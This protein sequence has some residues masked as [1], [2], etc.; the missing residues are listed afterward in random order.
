MP[1]I[2]INL[3]AVVLAAVANMV[4]GML[5]YGPLFG[6]KWQALMGFTPESMKSMKMTAAQAIAG[7]CVTAF[8]MAYV[9]AHDAFVWG[10]FFGTS[11]APSVFA[12]QLAFWIWLGYVATTQ[13]GAV[14]WEGRP[15]KLFVLNAG[16]SLVSLI[17]MSLILTYIR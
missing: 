13:I 4:V 5:W 11:V 2:E 3:I 16:N 6:K 12:L 14:L 15:W 1:T 7:G 8:I 17:A 9:L 10:A